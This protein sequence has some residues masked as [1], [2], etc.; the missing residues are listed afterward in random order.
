MTLVEDSR[1]DSALQTKRS[2]GGIKGRF[3]VL[4]A[5]QMHVAFVAAV[6]YNSEPAQSAAGILPSLNT[7]SGFMSRVHPNEEVSSKRELRETGC[8]NV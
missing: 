6:Q 4:N 8:P 7:Y 5:V 1:S 2:G 3:I